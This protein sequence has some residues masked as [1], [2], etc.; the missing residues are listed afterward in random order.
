MGRIREVSCLYCYTPPLPLLDDTSTDCVEV[1]NRAVLIGGA[2][3][4]QDRKST[5]LN[6]SHLR[7]SRMPSSA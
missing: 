1:Q 7:A 3:D 2:H 5:R 4:D 6:S